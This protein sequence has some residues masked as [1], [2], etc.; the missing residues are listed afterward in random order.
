M[1]QDLLCEWVERGRSSELLNYAEGV[2]EDTNAGWGHLGGIKAYVVEGT[3]DSVELSFQRR[4]VGKIK[5][6]CAAETWVVRTV[7][8]QAN[9]VV[10]DTGVRIYVNLTGQAGPIKLL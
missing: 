10:P 1:G 6:S 4:N 2:R 5:Y 3:D 8:G 9:G 7:P